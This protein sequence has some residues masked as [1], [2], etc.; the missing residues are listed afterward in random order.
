MSLVARGKGQEEEKRQD[1]DDES[2]IRNDF[3]FCSSALFCPE[4]DTWGLL[5]LQDNT[6]LS[7]I[8]LSPEI[9]VAQNGMLLAAAEAKSATTASNIHG[10][11][12]WAIY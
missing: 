5:L 1:K 6:I 11:G 9:V 8:S 10:N 2:M 4:N 3:T 7:S 12:Q